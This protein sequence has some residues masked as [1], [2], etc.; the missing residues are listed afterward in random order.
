MIK[1]FRLYLMSV[2]LFFAGSIHLISPENFLPAIPSFIPLPEIIIY[3]TGILEIFI[4]FFLLRNK[5][6]DFSARF[7]ALYLLLLIP[8]HIY[9][10]YYGVE[11]F[12]I[13][14]K[15]LLWLRTGFQFVLYFW[16]LS[17][18]KSSWI[19]QQTWQNVFFIH[20][21]VSAKKLQ[22]LVPFEL[23]LYD[24]YAIISVIPFHMDAI[25]FPFLPTIPKISSLWELNIR[26]Y[27]NVKGVKGIYFFT[28]ETDSKLGEL[29][30][31]SFFNLPYRFSKIKAST[32]TGGFYSVEY[33][34]DNLSFN[35]QATT[36]DKAQQTQL[37][38]WTT[39]RYS[40]FTKKNGVSFQGI[41]KHLPWS[42]TS[43]KINQINNQFTKMVI[44]DVG[45]VIGTSYA[46]D[47]KVSFQNFKKMEI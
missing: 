43:A 37:D 19:I 25:R 2:F 3:L 9:M 42:L 1:P 33:S 4:A 10:A 18:Q 36:N 30:A 38:L 23:D 24:N 28:L 21:R 15:L 16:A 34:R 17:L 45:E 40:L 35:M 7:L 11:I 47:I 8:I 5:T 32:A 39:E 41:V 22:K 29:I 46:K 27:V 26:T 44:P 13:D 20:Y 14:N 31:R 6:Q 12:G